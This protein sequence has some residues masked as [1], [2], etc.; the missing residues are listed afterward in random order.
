MT[1]TSPHVLLI[2]HVDSVI[3]SSLH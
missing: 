1:R 3:N 2:I